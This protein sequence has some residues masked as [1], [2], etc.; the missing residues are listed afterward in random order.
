MAHDKLEK[1]IEVL[2]S[3]KNNS[4][5]FGKSLAIE[6][7][8][9]LLLFV[10][11]N[12]ISKNYNDLTVSEVIAKSSQVGASK[13]AL[14]VGIDGLISGYKGFGLSK[15]PQNHS[16]SNPKPSQILLQDHSFHLSRGCR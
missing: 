13:L 2:F 8:R 11:S 7:R 14:L 15:P 12:N 10:E 16:K 3:K 9:K 1:K 4:I 5:G 6:K